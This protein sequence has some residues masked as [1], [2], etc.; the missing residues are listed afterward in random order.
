[1]STA[2]ESGA[3]A[4]RKAEEKVKA[5]EVKAESALKTAKKTVKKATV[6]KKKPTDKKLAVK[7][8]VQFAGR[9]YTIADLQKQAEAYYKEQTGKTSASLKTLELYVK[10]E[11]SRVYVVADG[12]EVGSFEI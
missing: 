12:N 1:M 6:S 5:A 2:K 10:P 11:E 9:A 3:A 7:V 8:E 4:V